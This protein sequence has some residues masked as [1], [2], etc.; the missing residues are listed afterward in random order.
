MGVTVKRARRRA[1]A[2]RRQS[3]TL[4]IFAIPAKGCVFLS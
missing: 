4:R 1:H 3:I 2:A